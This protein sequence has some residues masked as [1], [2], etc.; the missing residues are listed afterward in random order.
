MLMLK[1]TIFKNIVTLIIDVVMTWKTENMG[2][3][4]PVRRDFDLSGSL[5]DISNIF[6]INT[7]LTSCTGKKN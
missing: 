6:T 5:A 4:W 2:L 7:N 1:V 3:L